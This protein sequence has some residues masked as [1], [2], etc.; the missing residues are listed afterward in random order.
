MSH[1]LSPGK[2]LVGEERDVPEAAMTFFGV[3]VSDYQK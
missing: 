3:G 1:M 2:A